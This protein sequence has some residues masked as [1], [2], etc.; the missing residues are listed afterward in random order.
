[1]GGRVRCFQ[2][3]STR[4]KRLAVLRGDEPTRHQ[5]MNGLGQLATFP[6][7]WPADDNVDVIVAPDN[8]FSPPRSIAPA[9]CGACRGAAGSALP[10]PFL[11]R[12]ALS[13]RTHTHSGR[14]RDGLH[15]PL[16]LISSSSA[17][18]VWSSNRSDG[19]D[20]RAGRDG[21]ERDWCCCLFGAM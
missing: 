21:R 15:P 12:G 1:M 17:A 8:A 14:V 5:A 10:S 11:Q 19:R 7:R 3:P 2:R 13:R 18:A 20:G 4:N 9:Q 6:A 16:P